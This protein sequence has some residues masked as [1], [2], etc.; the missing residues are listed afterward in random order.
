MKQKKNI[1]FQ[2]SGFRITAFSFKAPEE[3]L[4]ENES[5]DFETSVGVS[6]ESSALIVKVGIVVR[7]SLDQVGYATM[8]AESLF[9]TEGLDVDSHTGA[10]VDV[11]PDFYATVISLAISTTR[12]ALLVKGAGSF[13]ERVPLPIVDPKAY[14]P[15]I[16]EANKPSVG[17]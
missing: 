1:G 15:A 10:V 8:V 3:P 9:S 2:F 5:F 6:H 16:M 11:P 4:G 12:G 13:L 7:R 17:G 14:V